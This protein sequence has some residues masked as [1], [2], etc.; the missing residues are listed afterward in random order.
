MDG[1][2]L[3]SV[4]LI[5][6]P[7]E[8]KQI[9]RWV[10][11]R[12]DRKANGRIDKLP[13]DKND[14]RRKVNSLGNCE[15]WGKIL[16]KISGDRY[17]GLGFY[18]DSDHTGLVGID[19]DHVFDG[20]I[21][22]L[23]PL[24]IVEELDSYTE[25]S[26]SETGLH[27]W[28]RSRFSP[29]NHNGQVLEV[30]SKGNSYL[31]VTGKPYGSPKPIADRTEILMDLINR[32]FPKPTTTKK[33]TW[34]EHRDRIILRNDDTDTLRKLWSKP[35]RRKLWEGDLTGYSSPNGDTS[36][37]SADLTLCNYIYLCSNQDPEAIDRLFR[38]SG[39]MRD[40]WDEIHSRDG[41]TYGQMTIQKVLTGKGI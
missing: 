25:F 33:D 9:D 27:I 36:Q 14:L 5:F 31:T 6:I 38:R 24:R 20:M 16:R 13:L 1:K 2:K 39:L 11:W 12:A 15:P 4:N 29:E 17:L 34:E 23:E 22:R 18:P 8:M 10:C 32:Y 30:K 28:I 3:S 40:K 35:E 37:S 21:A 19:L 41:L 7:D 26:P